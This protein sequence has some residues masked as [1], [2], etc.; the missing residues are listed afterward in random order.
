MV[1]VWVRDPEFRLLGPATILQPPR[2]GAQLDAHL[3]EDALLAIHDRNPVRRVVMDMTAGEQ[4]SQWIADTLDAEVVDRS[5]G[6][7]MAVLDHTRFMEALRMGWL[8]HTGDPGLTR[9]VLN[10][11]TRVL[12]GGDARFS[13]PAE[14]R[15]VN[16]AL[17]SRR[18][19]D[20]LVAAAMVH[21]AACESSEAF[22]VAF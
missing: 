10:A 16:E 7:A 21:C 9:H 8:K 3:V 11:I 22:V 4:L 15:T 17:A 2:N 19:I 20:A 12:P 13:R 5:Q 1:P 14:S 18:H 6:N